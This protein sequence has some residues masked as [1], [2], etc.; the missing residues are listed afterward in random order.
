MPKKKAISQDVVTCHKCGHPIPTIPVWLAG[1]DV[2]F[3]CEE[4]RQRQAGLPSIAELTAAERE[5]DAVPADE[6]AEEAED[7]LEAEAEDLDDTEVPDDMP[8]DMEE[9]EEE[10]SADD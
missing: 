2:L 8:D 10:V 6:L 3:E 1:A 5:P 7:I 4:C 9:L